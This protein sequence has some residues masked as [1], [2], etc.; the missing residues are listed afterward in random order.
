[1]QTCEECGQLFSTLHDLT[2]HFISVHHPNYIF[3]S[4][5]QGQPLEA[6][7][8]RQPRNNQTQL[9]NPQYR[10]QIA[11]QYP[12]NY[13]PWGP[14]AQH[15][16]PYAEPT[17][18]RPWSQNVEYQHPNASPSHVRPFDLNESPNVRPFDLNRPATSK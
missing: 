15:Q 13:N 6:Q 12:S 2:S 18:V 14:N 8:Q 3:D 16:P 11:Q 17:Q 7:P 10:P 9:P 4:S 1:M 5:L